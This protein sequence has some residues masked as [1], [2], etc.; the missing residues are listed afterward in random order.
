MDLVCGR[1]LILHPADAQYTNSSSSTTSTK[2]SSSS[3]SSSSYTGPCF[4]SCQA[5]QESTQFYW[6]K[7]A[8]TA[9]IL[10]AKIILVFNKATN[11][12]RTETSYYP[13]PA[14]HTLPPRNA[15]GVHI[16]TIYVNTFAGDPKKEI[17][18]YA[19]SLRSLD[20]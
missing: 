4:P 11:K 8:V 10:A 12:T 3:A 6:A 2:A 19:S 20:T 7:Q 9:T 14:G 16:T 18:L 15:A 1:L 17:V 5:V 13:L